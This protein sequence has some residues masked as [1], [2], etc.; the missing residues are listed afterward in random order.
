MHEE[1]EEHSSRPPGLMRQSR[2]VR[3]DVDVES[4]KSRE[5]FENIPI[6]IIL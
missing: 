3:A 5:M 2:A 4:T 1:L 6:N